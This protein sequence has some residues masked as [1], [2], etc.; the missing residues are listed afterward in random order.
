MRRRMRR[1]LAHHAA[2]SEAVEITVADAARRVGK[3]KATLLRAIKSGTISAARDAATGAF[4]LDEA[5]LHRV[6]AAVPP[7]NG[8]AKATHAAADEASCSALRAQLEAAA[9]RIEELRDSQRTRDDTIADLRRR[10]DAEAE[11]RRR[12]TAILA[13]QR[14]PPPA[15]RRSW[16]PWQRRS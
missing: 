10:L 2:G 4:R 13:D 11:E 15:P 7:A 8:A 9:A 14:L 3:S 12:L 6:F 5:E 1:C 16:W